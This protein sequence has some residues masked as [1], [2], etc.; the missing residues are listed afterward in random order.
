M[1]ALRSG[2]LGRRRY[3]PPVRAGTTDGARGHHRYRFERP[4][5]TQRIIAQETITRAETF[6]SAPTTTSIHG[7]APSGI[8][9]PVTTNIALALQ[10]PA[11]CAPTQLAYSPTSSEYLMRPSVRG[12]ARRAGHAPAR[13]NRRAAWTRPMVGALKAAVGALATMVVNPDRR[14]SS[15]IRAP[16]QTRE[17]LAAT[18]AGAR[19]SASATVSCLYLQP[20]AGADLCEFPNVGIHWRDLPGNVG[21]HPGGAKA[22]RDR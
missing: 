16:C 13:P 3:S 6:S 19:V 1:K 15:A 14:P 10:N 12:D 7:E 9:A 2:R 11:S 17:R 4:R 8:R 18:D 22:R 5:D 20:V 21:E